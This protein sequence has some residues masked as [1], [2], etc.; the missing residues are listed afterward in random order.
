MIERQNPYA[1]PYPVEQ[2]EKLYGRRGAIEQLSRGLFPP[3]VPLSQQIVG[4]TRIGK[5]SLLN[6][7]SR[8]NDLNYQ[9][10]A[11]SF[12]L[13]REQ[14]KRTLFVQVNFEG[15]SANEAP[16]FWEM[17]GRQL[18]QAVQS[19]FP[20]GRSEL[21]RLQTTTFYDFDGQGLSPLIRDGL[22]II[23]L[24]DEFDRVAL[25]LPIDVSHNMRFLLEKYTGSLVYIT[26]TRRPLYQYYYEERDDAKGVSPLFNYFAPE[27]FYLGLLEDSA[28]PEGKGLVSF[29]REPARAYGVDFTNKDV[30][31]ALEN[32]GGHPDI[33]R[34]V[35]MHL[36]E[37]R[38]QNPRG[39]LDYHALYEQIIR[40]FEPL[41]HVI[42]SEL[43]TSQR[44][45][46]VRLAT[47]QSKSGEVPEQLIQ[48]GL[49]VRSG[50]GYR[51]FSPVLESFLRQVDTG[52]ARPAG[53]RIWPEQ[54]GIQ[55]GNKLE[56]LSPQEWDLFTYL[57]EH[58]GQIC[59]REDLLRALSSGNH[60]LTKAALE[61]TVSRLRQKLEYDPARPSLIVTVR[62]RGYRL[63]EQALGRAA[64]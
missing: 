52:G 27:P 12:G 10:F 39:T 20:G 47:A 46:L 11:E 51:L 35:C 28:E 59:A 29:I 26:A 43:S 1:N 30:E 23:L 54:R 34:L 6:V 36:F 25:R 13:E 60:N 17:M 33:T 56:I 58:A 55:I 5:T 32:G 40:S 64:E 8:L 53:L 44:D 19:Q 24:L 7:M 45:A 15:L 9:T 3:E 50:S 42:W 4:L 31:F 62:G 21:L 22:K 14:L 38:R 61:I 2:P 41:Y 49:I 63:E 48:L 57:Y 16:S 37:A 18:R